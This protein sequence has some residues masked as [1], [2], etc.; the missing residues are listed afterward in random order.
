MSVVTS[1]APL[2]PSCVSG[3]S[4]RSSYAGTAIGMVRDLINSKKYQIRNQFV[5][6]TA[7]VEEAKKVLHEILKIDERILHKVIE[8][9][10]P[11]DG[12]ILIKNIGKGPEVEDQQSTNDQKRYEEGVLNKS[13]SIILKRCKSQVGLGNKR[14]TNILGK[15][16]CDPPYA[17]LGD[18][19]RMLALESASLSFRTDQIR[20]FFR[21]QLSSY[22]EEHIPHKAFY[23]TLCKLLQASHHPSSLAL[24]QI[25]DT[26][27]VLDSNNTGFVSLT[28]FLKKYSLEL[29]KKPSMRV[30][31][32]RENPLRWSG[33]PQVSKTEP[34][35][36]KHPHPPRPPP[37]YMRSLRSSGRCNGLR[38]ADSQCLN[39]SLSEISRRDGIRKGR[40]QPQKITKPPSGPKPHRKHIHSHNNS[41]SALQKYRKNAKQ[42]T[43]RRCFS[44]GHSSARVPN[45]S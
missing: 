4:A 19:E 29:L 27:K 41:R 45:M 24:D 22:P 44:A 14:P 38:L 28:E 23:N 40:L 31:L 32:G 35:E 21:K 12:R 6:G 1:A 30:T 8:E 5:D 3:V 33:V 43:D 18:T 37:N 7:T 16:Q 17:V 11:V 20:N 25:L 36:Q 34:D 13:M 2:V 26:M 39:L 9:A 10:N 15:L 42:S